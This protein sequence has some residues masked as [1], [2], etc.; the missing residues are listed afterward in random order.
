[1]LF[2]PKDARIPSELR[3]A[4]FI[5]RPLRATDVEL[6]YDAVMTSKEMLRVWE[7]SDW[8]VDDF[9]QADNLQDLQRHEKEHLERSAF[10]FTVMNPT[11]TECLGC[12]YIYPLEGMLKHMKAGE[13]ELASVNDYQ[14]SASFWVRQS[15]LAD[16]LDQFLLDTLITWFKRDWAFSHVVF[17][18]NSQNERQVH[19]LTEAGLQKLYDFDIPNK[20]PKYLIY[21]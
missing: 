10:T 17:N 1:M 9:T 12:V 19:L 8:P 7:Q 14:A 15:R 11:E 18:I 21:G 6:D 5:L 13:S 2:Y 3:T 20:K 16:G 4:E